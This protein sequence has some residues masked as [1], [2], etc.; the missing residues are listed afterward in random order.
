MKKIL[1]SAITIGLSATLSANAFEYLAPTN[2]ATRNFSPIIRHQFEKQET[3][4]FINK[5]E[6]YKI[7]REKKDAYLD[8]KEG[9]TNEIPSF[10]KPQIN[11]ENQVPATTNM[12]FKKDENGQIKI[13]GIQ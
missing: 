1:L 4:D 2:E 5:P 3:M 11:V 10:L 12:E 7:K 8:Y 6:E 13:Q 9:K